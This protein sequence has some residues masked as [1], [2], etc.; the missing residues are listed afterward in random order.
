[1][2]HINIFALILITAMLVAC[3]TNPVTKKKE[4]Q[5][6]SE[7]QE[8]SIGQQNYSPARQSQG[9]DYIIDPEL[10]TYVQSVGQKLAAVSDRPELPYEFIVL[11]DSIPNAWAMPGGKIAFN[12]GLLYE[13]NNEAELAAVL[14]HEIVHAAARHGAKSM[15]RG[16]FIQGA[17]IAVGIGAQN[18]D[19]ANL[20]V[21]GSQLGAQLISSKYGRDAESESDHYG[22]NYMKKAD[23][24][25]MAAVTLQETFV[26]LSAGKNSDFISGLF[27]SHP[28]SQARV[29]ANKETLAKLGAGGEW[30]KEIYAQKVGKLKATQ[31]AY[32]A[33]DDGVAALKK[34]DVAM[35]TQLAQKAIA[36]EPREARFQELLGD[37]AFTQ[38]KPQ[39]ALGYYDKAI[40]LQP[41]YFKPYIQSGIALFNMGKKKEAEPFLTRA[42]ELLPTAPGHALL[43]QIAEERGEIDQ[44]LQHYQVAASSNSDIGKDATARAVRIDLPRNPA[45]YLQSGPMADNNGDVYAVVQNAT[46]V[47]M[48]RVRVHVVKYDAKSGRPIAQS[49]SMLISGGIA[50][51]K[52][53]Q[54]AIGERVNTQQEL[55]LYKVVVDAAEVAN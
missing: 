2:K 52:R 30:G 13:L 15:E 20:I 48:G 32:K 11:N 25:P 24:D 26:R 4:F 31:P 7:S 10:T 5:F 22:M 21:G 38:K 37:I 1:M 9:G 19:Y 51:G 33:Y 34:G 40:K 35:A 47:P 50:P 23:Y 36:G 41:D 45:K 54:I 18:S 43:G 16:M 53:N 49:G 42:N 17:M 8:I 55:R 3:G 28:P 46:S 27:A 44:A 14:G 6:V 29:D 12:R 39:E